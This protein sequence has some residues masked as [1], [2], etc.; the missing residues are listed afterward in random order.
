MDS[1]QPVS[2]CDQ[3]PVSGNDLLL[4]LHSFEVLY[5]IRFPRLAAVGRV[6]LLPVTRRTSD[7]GPNESYA[8]WLSILGI[9][10]VKGAHAI[11][12]AALYGGIHGSR[13]KSTVHPLDRPLPRLGVK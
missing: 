1:S 3:R 11:A 9:V 7:L 2:T 5:P 13:R 10:S 8:D 12:E 6:R 4:L